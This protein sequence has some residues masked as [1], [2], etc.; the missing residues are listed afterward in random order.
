MAMKDLS[1]LANNIVV[2]ETSGTERITLEQ[3]KELY[4]KVAR[5]AEEQNRQLGETYI[6]L[7]TEVAIIRFSS[8]MKLVLRVSNNRAIRKKDLDVVI[9]PKF[10]GN[11][12]PIPWRAFIWTE[13]RLNWW[14]L[15]LVGVIFYVLLMH[16]IGFSNI[17]TLNQMLVEANA[18]FIG[19]F[20]LF[21]IT[22]NRE[23]LATRELVR[24]GITHQLMQNDYYITCLAILSLI[25]AF[26]STAI[27]SG[28]TGN[29]S[30]ITEFLLI[31]RLLNSQIGPQ[32]LTTFSLLLLLDCF[33]AVTSYY[34]RVMRTALESRMYIELMAEKSLNKEAD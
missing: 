17:R 26:I 4:R 34:L 3:F 33:L 32:I 5:L 22:Q 7:L 6:L 15:L 25:V 24:Q 11:I 12:N 31:Q 9:T 23:L 2:G 20:V 8:A 18:L 19:I 14:K 10:E 21:T 16:D 30:S 13:I 28:T 29:Q 1:E 27:T